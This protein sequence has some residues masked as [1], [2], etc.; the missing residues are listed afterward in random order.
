MACGLQRGG[1]CIF[2]DILQHIPTVAQA[3]IVE[4][5]A[6]DRGV[7]RISNRAVIKVADLAF[8]RNGYPGRPRC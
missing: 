1:D 8:E 3:Q 5:C 4:Q 7:A 2:R 6:H